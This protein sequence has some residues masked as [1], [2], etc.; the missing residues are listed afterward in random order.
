MVT[1]IPRNCGRINTME[2]GR[3]PGTDPVFHPPVASG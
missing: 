2:N 1:A 3:A